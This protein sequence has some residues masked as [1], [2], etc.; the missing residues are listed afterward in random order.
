MTW[1]GLTGTSNGCLNMADMNFIRFPDDFVG[2]IVDREKENFYNEW[3]PGT[4]GHLIYIK[5]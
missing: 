1:H 3:C 4:A 5:I 2:A